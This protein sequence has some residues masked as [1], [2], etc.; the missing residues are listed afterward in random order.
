MNTL[1]DLFFVK[2]QVMVSIAMIEKVVGEIVDLIMSGILVVLLITQTI[3]GRVSVSSGVVSG[4]VACG[5]VAI[6]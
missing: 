5:I 1:S 6:S 3:V 2:E 4:L